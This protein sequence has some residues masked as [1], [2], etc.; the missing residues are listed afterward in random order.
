MPMQTPSCGG[1]GLDLKAVRQQP[2]GGPHLSPHT[3]KA[4]LSASIHSQ[5]P[6]LRVEQVQPPVGDRGHRMIALH[7]RAASQELREHLRAVQ[8]AWG[9]QQMLL[10]GCG[11]GRGTE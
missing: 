10:A 9:G 6:H 11:G 3:P 4:A 7:Q 2:I 1:A 8:R 5:N